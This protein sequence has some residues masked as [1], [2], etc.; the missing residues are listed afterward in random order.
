MGASDADTSFSISMALALKFAEAGMD[1][2]YQLVWEQPHC[3][4][5]YAGEVIDWIES[6]V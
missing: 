4:A 2:D 1:T 5:D 3:E 6:I